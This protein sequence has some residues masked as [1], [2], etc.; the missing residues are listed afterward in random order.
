VQHVVGGTHNS[1]LVEMSDYLI[2][3]DAPVTDWQSNWTLAAAKQKYPGKPIRYLV[4]THHHMDHAGGIR[5]YVAQGAALVVGMGAAD[6]YR[7][8]LAA[9]YTRNPDLQPRSLSGV[10]IIEVGDKH[11]FADGKR[12]VS[13]HV[14]ENPHAA[15][16]LMG[17]VADA[18]LAYVTDVYTPGPPLPAKINPA[19]AAVVNG[20]RKAGIQPLTFA[21]GHGS[22]APYA[23]LVALASN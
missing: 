5:G 3:F 16:M 21:G 6:H 9:S 20:V 2:A 15:A 8:T 7:R 1:L 10:T 22:T 11:V 14:L 4:M 12:E 19:L 13:A 18:R 17:Y 23:L